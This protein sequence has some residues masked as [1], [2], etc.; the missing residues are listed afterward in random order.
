MGLLYRLASLSAWLGNLYQQDMLNTY[1]SS[2]MVQFL[3][4]W[5]V[6]RD[7][8]MASNILL[9]DVLVRVFPKEVR[10]WLHRLSKGHLHQCG[11]HRPIH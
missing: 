9:L 11:G 2:V 3:V 6:L 7:A 10:I 8:W 4:I 1:V 5:T